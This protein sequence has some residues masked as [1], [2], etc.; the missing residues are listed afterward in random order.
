M[1]LVE[2]L[3]KF[4]RGKLDEIPTGEVEIKRLS[5]LMGEPFI[6]KCQAISGEMYA[7]IGSIMANKK[8]D[9]D[10]GKSYKVNTLLAVSGVIEPDLKN[11]ELQKHFGCKTPKDLVEVLFKG[12]DMTKVA[13]LVTELSGFAP[14]EDEEIKN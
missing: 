10:M 4:D 6:V 11:E 9:L 2:K 14:E 5:K 3:M 12:G 13:D 7:E 1:N 8:G